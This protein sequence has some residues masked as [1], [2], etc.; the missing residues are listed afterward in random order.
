MSHPAHQSMIELLRGL[1]HPEAPI[2]KWE[3]WA[4]G[5]RR[6]R[7]ICITLHTDEL[8]IAH[9]A[10]GTDGSM[11]QLHDFTCNLESLPQLVLRL[12]RALAAANKRGLIKQSRK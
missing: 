9:R 8:K 4:N 10:I 12:N 7:T 6:S 1:S 11:S 2:Q 3:F 5:R